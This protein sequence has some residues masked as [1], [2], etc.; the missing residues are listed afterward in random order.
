[1]I[2]HNRPESFAFLYSRFD[3]HSDAN[4]QEMIAS[5]NWDATARDKTM[6]LNMAYLN[7]SIGI[8]D[9]MLGRDDFKPAYEIQIWP[10]PE[11]WTL[12]EIKDLISHHPRRA[13]LFV[14][15]LYSPREGALE[16]E[17][18]LMQIEVNLHC[19]SVNKD[20]ASNKRFSPTTMLNDL[21]QSNYSGSDQDFATVFDRLIAAGAA[22]DEKMRSDFAQMHPEHEMAEHTLFYSFNEDIKEP[23][24]D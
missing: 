21:I 18:T 17:E 9:F 12:Q 13:K 10:I 20:I 22:V 7:H 6:L 23:G 15:Q 1:M 4:L 2:E 19:A 3:F 16:V 24:C 11:P 5:N 8:C 14:A